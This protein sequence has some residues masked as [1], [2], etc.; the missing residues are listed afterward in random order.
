M[1]GSLERGPYALQANEPKIWVARSL[2]ILD[3]D[4]STVGHGKGKRMNGQAR[5]LIVGSGLWSM[6]TAYHGRGEEGAYLGTQ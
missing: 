5:V 2:D 6:S 1:L 3:L 4:R